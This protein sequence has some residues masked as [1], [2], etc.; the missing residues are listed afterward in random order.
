[1]FHADGL[2][3]HPLSP[4]IFQRKYS[5]PLAQFNVQVS[6]LRSGSCL[7]SSGVLDASI[8]DAFTYLRGVPSE[9][10]YSPRFGSSHVFPRRRCT[11]FAPAGTVAAGNDFALLGY[12]SPPDQ[13]MLMLAGLHS[14]NRRVLA[15]INAMKNIDPCEI[16]VARTPTNCTADVAYPAG[17]PRLG[18]ASKCQVLH[19]YYVVQSFSSNSRRRLES[20]GK[21]RVRGG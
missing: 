2:P 10:F 14:H 9:P 21:A 19:T 4:S 5:P 15:P 8:A 7:R 16:S 3:H 6:G 20:R 18:C 17:G 1:M 13:S 12:A 11:N